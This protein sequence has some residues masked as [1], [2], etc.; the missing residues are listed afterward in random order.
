MGEHG[1]EA[2]EILASTHV[3]PSEG[4]RESHQLWEQAHIVAA[5]DAYDA[6]DFQSAKEHLMMAL[7]FTNV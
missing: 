4:A 1:V 3:L 6:A 2:A 5:M 7:L